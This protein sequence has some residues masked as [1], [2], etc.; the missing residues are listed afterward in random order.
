MNLSD[1]DTRDVTSRRDETAPIPETEAVPLTETEQVPDPIDSDEDYGMV[2]ILENRDV[3]GLDGNS[4]TVTA[5]DRIRTYNTYAQRFDN[6]SSEE[7]NEVF[8]E[9]KEI[10]HNGVDNNYNSDEEEEVV[11]NEYAPLS[12]EFGEFTSYEGF[13][14]EED[15]GAGVFGIYGEVNMAKISSDEEDNYNNDSLA[16]HT[17]SSEP[18]QPY[19]SIPPLDQGKTTTHLAFLH[20]NSA[21]NNSLCERVTVVQS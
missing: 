13:A 18:I 1:Q 3:N 6:Y 19:I 14:Q 17:V 8:H 11:T 2:S 9:R 12:V 16:N 4:R 5:S 7:E 10:D 20:P 15:E 21:L